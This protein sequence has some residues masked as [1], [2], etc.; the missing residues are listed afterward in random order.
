MDRQNEVVN[1]NLGDMLRCLVGE[2]LGNWD[3]ILPNIEFA[4][5]NSVNRFTGKSHFEIVTG[6]SPCQPIDLVPLSIDYRSLNWLKTLLSIFVLYMK[7]LKETF[8]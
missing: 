7:K 5:N 4:C 3:L 6:Y 8:P 1:C 2:K